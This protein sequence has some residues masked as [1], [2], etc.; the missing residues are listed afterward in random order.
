MK[1]F[2]HLYQE[3][4]Q[5]DKTL[6]FLMA[7][8]RQA[9]ERCATLPPSKYGVVPKLKITDDIDRNLYELGSIDTTYLDDLYTDMN[10]TGLY[11]GN[12][13]VLRTLY[14]QF[15]TIKQESASGGARSAARIEQAMSGIEETI[16]GAYLAL[17]ELGHHRLA[18]FYAG[19]S[20]IALA[21][22]EYVIA[23]YSREVTFSPLL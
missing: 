7:T 3:T 17:D 4:Q 11:R 20:S 19:A 12:N 21:V 13:E 22:K 14:N 8:L 9:A 2:W 10:A 16:E 6:S 23:H 5:Y 18:E 1:S 15:R